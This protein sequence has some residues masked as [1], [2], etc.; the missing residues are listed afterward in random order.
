[1]LLCNGEPPSRILARTL[2]RQADLVVAADG[3]ANVARVLGVPPNV[4]IG[5]L[6]SITPSTRRH[7]RSSLI[8]RLTRQDNTDLEKALDY[9]ASGGPAEVMILG[10]T[11]N[12]IDFTLANLAVIW[13]YTERLHLTVR[14]DGWR[15]FAVKRRADFRVRKGTT[16][17]LLPFGICRGITIRGMQYPLTNASMKVGDVGVSNVATVRRPV[18]RVRQG[19]MLAVVFDQSPR[20]GRP[21]AW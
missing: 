7:F 4:I 5:D 2:A 17:S 9:I 1:M 16:I 6:D 21:P 15:A 13:K 8:V 3:G 18:V 19:K 11:G 14:G 10:M 12:R 20:K